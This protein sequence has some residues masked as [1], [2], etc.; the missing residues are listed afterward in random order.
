MTEL[1]IDDV[2]R[3][4][5]EIGIVPVVRA[6]SVEEANRAVEAICAGG[7]PVVEITMTVPGAVELISHL[8]HS[9]PKLIV[10]GGTVL[11]TETVSYTHLTLPTKA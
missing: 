10:G 1:S 4:I 11:D 5:G 6:A 9:D 3:K 2:I 7:I 8:V